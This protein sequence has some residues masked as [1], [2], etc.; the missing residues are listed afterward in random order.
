MSITY[1]NHVLAKGPVGY[2][3]LGEASGM[4]A[5]DAVHRHNGTYHV[6]VASYR[7]AGAIRSDK[8]TSIKLDGDDY[9]QVGTSSAF[10]LP[11]SGAGL[12]VEAWLQP[13]TLVFS[14]ETADPYVH[15][16]GKGSQG[17]FEWGL[18]FYSRDSSRPNRIS[19]YVWNPKGGEG[20]GAFFQ[21]GLIPGQWIHVVACFDPGDKRSPTSGVRIYKN[22]VIRQGPPAPGT[23]YSNPAFKVTPGRGTAPLRLGTR[24]F[25][26]FLVGGLD[27]V[28]IYPRVL[29]AREVL[30]NY[31]AGIAP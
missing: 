2:W 10:S 31:H 27:E 4:T 22:G 26:S 12:T 28:A 24:D 5:T 3:R 13:S 6:G 19:A 8:N 1:H 29:T 30:D 25:G 17:Q 23:L 14:G 15:W 20:A 18:R 16:L 9:V 7:H 21:D 11:T